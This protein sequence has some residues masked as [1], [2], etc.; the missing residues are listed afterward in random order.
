MALF[1]RRTPRS[2]SDAGA[3]TDDTQIEVE[4][5]ELR[6]EDVRGPRDSAGE[7][8]PAGYVDLGVL[9]VPRIPGLKFQWKTPGAD[10]M[11][12]S[13]IQMVLGSSAVSA[14]LAAAPKSGG[15]WEELMDQITASLEGSGGSVERVQ[16]PYGEELR[17]RVPLA[18]PGGAKGVAPI[19]VVGVE[20][21]RWVL[22]LD[23]TGAAA[24]GDPLQI[25]ACEALI[26]RLIVN[27]G[28]HPWIRLQ[29][30]PLTLPK[31]AG[32]ANGPG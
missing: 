25:A 10:Q 21:P 8:S 3:K 14:T 27:R 17:A 15:A 16:G 1:R 2:Q 24:A 11:T 9:Y 7:R 28:T 23:I 20:G 12:I 29:V 31:G 30:L 32:T 6:E 19:R 26:D 4:A 22:R 18:L 5:V 13:S